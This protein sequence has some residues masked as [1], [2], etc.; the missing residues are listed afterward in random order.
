MAATSTY[1]SGTKTATIKKHSDGSDGWDHVTGVSIESTLDDT[2]NYIIEPRVTFSGGGVSAYADIAKGRV[3]VSDGKISEIRIWDPG[4]GYSG[5]PTFTLTDPNNTADV[6]HAVRYGDGVLRQ[7]TW[8]N[9]GTAFTT[10][11]ATI[12]GDGHADRYQP[13]ANIRI[14][15]LA[16]SPQSGANVAF[17][18]IAGK[19]FKLVRVTNLTGSGPFDATFQVSPDITT[20]EAP[21]HGEAVTVTIRYSQVR[22]TG[23]DFLDVGTGGT[24]STN[25]PGTPSTPADQ[26]DETKDYGGGR[27]FYTSTDQHGNFRVGELFKVEQ[28]T[29]IVTINASQFDLAGLDELRLGAFI[30][31]CTNSVIK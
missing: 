26:T 3:K 17:A 16:S 18:G 24:S 2:T 9:R 30:L 10:A 12:A 31:G 1:N 22:L 29:G 25:Y 20:T 28:S 11:Q 14:S 8:T 21:E 5:T 7:P 15:G 6:P 27:V 19:W 4:T 13:G 23:H